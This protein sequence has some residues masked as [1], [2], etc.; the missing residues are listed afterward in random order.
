MTVRRAVR[1]LRERGL[2][3][4]V[5][6]TYVLA[7]DRKPWVLTGPDRGKGPPGHPYGRSRSR[8]ASTTST[9]ISVR[10]SST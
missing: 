7:P 4:T 1:Q 2:A 6:G 10:P 9:T 8:R 3:E 5:N